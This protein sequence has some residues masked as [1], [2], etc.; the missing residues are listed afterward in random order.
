MYKIA[1]STLWL[2]KKLIYLPTCRSTNDYALALLNKHALIEGTTVITSAQTAGRGQRGNRWESQA[3]Q[4][5]TFSV[6]LYPKFLLPSEQF[7]LN[8]WVSVS[9]WETLDRWLPNGMKIKWPNDLYFREQKI[10]GILIE[11]LLQGQQITAS[12][13]GIGLNVNQVSFAYKQATSVRQVL[14]KPQQLDVLWE[15]VLQSL[16]KNYML[17]KQGGFHALKSRYLAQ[18]YRYQ[19]VHRYADCR[20]EP[21]TEFEGEILGVDTQGRLAIVRGQHVVY[22]GMKEIAFLF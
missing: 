22:F 8:V 4:N 16:E 7:A 9:V 13:V 20:T 10:G 3:D 6:V 19:A 12:V 14:G 21:P 17:L 2:G 5:L 15:D 18:L 1:A 11:N